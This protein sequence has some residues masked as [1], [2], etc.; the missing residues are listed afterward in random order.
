M[1]PHSTSPQP[2]LQ[3]NTQISSTFWILL[4]KKWHCLDDCLG[5]FTCTHFPYD[6]TMLLQNAPW[7]CWKSGFCW[8]DQKGKWDLISTTSPSLSHQGSL[9]TKPPVFHIT[10]P[11]L[12]CPVKGTG[13]EENEHEE[14]ILAYIYIG[15]T[16]ARSCPAFCDPTDCSVPG[17]SLHEIF[18]VRILERVAISSFRVSSWPR[19]WICVSCIGR[20]ILYHWATG[21]PLYIG[22]I[23]IYWIYIHIN[24]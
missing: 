21:E 1:L 16:C 9:F 6:N 22:Y 20:Q 19:D 3:I 14:R 24:R 2:Q 8:G 11:L 13:I 23:H 7:L 10:C 18:L 4:R 15:Y 5:V 17:S 12:S